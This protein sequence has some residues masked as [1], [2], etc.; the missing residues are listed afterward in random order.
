[1]LAANLPGI[2]PAQVQ[3]GTLIMHSPKEHLVW[4]CRAAGSLNLLAAD[5]LTFCHAAQVQPSAA[6]VQQGTPAVQSPKKRPRRPRR[7]PA[8]ASAPPGALGPLGQRAV[9]ALGPDLLGGS[10]RPGPLFR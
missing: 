5:D 4:P 6:Q 8:P 1:M 2:V 10:P 3:Q 7:A 9:Q